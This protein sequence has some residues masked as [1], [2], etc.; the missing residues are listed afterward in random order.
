MLQGWGA[1]E[2]PI[3][4]SI[5]DLSR[6]YGVSRAHIIRLLREAEAARLMAR[7]GNSLT[8]TETCRDAAANFNATM[9]LLFKGVV[10]RL[11]T[12]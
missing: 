6:R 5:A 11:V 9:M 12:P 4:L 1:P 2:Q 8:M 3:D 7:N 10:D